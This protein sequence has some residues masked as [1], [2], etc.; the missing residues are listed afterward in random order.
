[1]KGRL[2]F[3]ETLRLVLNRLTLNDALRLIYETESDDGR[4]PRNGIAPAVAV[5][6][7]SLRNSS[8]DTPF[9]SALD[10]WVPSAD[11]QIIEAGERSGDVQGALNRLSA[12]TKRRGE[13]SAIVWKSIISPLSNLGMLLLFIIMF[14]QSMVPMLIGVSPRNQWV[15]VAWAMGVAMDILG[16]VLPFILGA[17]PLFAVFLYWA[18]PNMT[19]SVRRVLDGY[20]PFSWYR[21]IKGGEFMLTIAAMID[22]GITEKECIEFLKYRASPWLRERLSA[23]DFALR[24]RAANVG[25][26]MYASRMNFPD[27]RL[28]RLLRALGSSAGAQMPSLADDWLNTVSAT[29]DKS[30]GR[31]NSLIK[32]MLYSMVS[33]MIAGVFSIVMAMASKYGLG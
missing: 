3:Y 1:M 9:S 21:A 11:V 23:I 8:S 27:A 4:K 10:G 14:E 5:W 30:L 26:A 15:G 17:I 32:L 24:T 7:Y 29:I 6:R 33:L 19:G 18:L 25:E 13:L 2:D 22:S 31:T 28:I 16:T 12:L 20:P